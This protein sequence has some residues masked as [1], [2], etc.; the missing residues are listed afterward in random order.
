MKDLLVK[1]FISVIMI[2]L[3][4]MSCPGYCSQRFSDDERRKRANL[5]QQLLKKYDKK[6]GHVR[7]VGGKTKY[8][9]EE[10]FVIE[11]A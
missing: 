8:E 3:I 4:W 10:N 7:L 5:I 11:L 1:I 9:G 6:D 2:D